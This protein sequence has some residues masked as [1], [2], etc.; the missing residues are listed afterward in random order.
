MNVKLDM[1]EVINS[2]RTTGHLPQDFSI[3]EV[4]VSFNQYE[5]KKRKPKWENILLCECSE[6]DLFG[7]ID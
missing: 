5:G 7:F 4:S 2:L 6:L 3:E 1:Y